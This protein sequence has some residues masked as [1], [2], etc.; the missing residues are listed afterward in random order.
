[1]FRLGGRP[2]PRHLCP[3]CRDGDPATPQGRLCARTVSKASPDE[4]TRRL[5]REVPALREEATQRP[6]VSAVTVSFTC[7]AGAGVG[8]RTGGMCLPDRE[9]GREN[10]RLSP[11]P[12]FPAQPGP[13]FLERNVKF[14]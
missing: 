6:S 11:A 10:G 7:S 13:A 2:P 9:G 5:C 3:C 1:M 4:A 12:G 14:N 8:E